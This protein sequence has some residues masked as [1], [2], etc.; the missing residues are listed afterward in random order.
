MNVTER[1]NIELYN[2]IDKE[3][4]FNVSQSHLDKVSVP[5]LIQQ[6]GIG[7]SLVHSHSVVQY[8]VRQG[9]YSTTF[10]L[11]L[12]K[13]SQLKVNLLVLFGFTVNS[14]F[15][16]CELVCFR[17]GSFIYVAHFKHRGNLKCFA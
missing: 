7:G 5:T 15:I 16:L 2:D 9:L 6:I 11:H 10:L 14:Y 12:T 3:I 13:Q 4:V 17:Q 1:I 8:T